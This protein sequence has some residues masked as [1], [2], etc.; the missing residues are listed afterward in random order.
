MGL[1]TMMTICTASI[2]EHAIITQICMRYLGHGFV[3]TAMKHIPLLVPVVES[4]IQTMSN[5]I[6][7]SLKT[8]C[9]M[10]AI[11]KKKGSWRENKENKKKLYF[12]L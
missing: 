1:A 5:D 9:A 11:A 12:L 10:I 3:R 8:S 6:A 7:K 2:A 4:V